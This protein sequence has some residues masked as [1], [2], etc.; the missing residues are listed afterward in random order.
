MPGMA[1][2][3]RLVA[4]DRFKALLGAEGGETRRCP[5]G[6]PV[7]ASISDDFEQSLHALAPDRRDEHGWH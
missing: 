1:S 4:S 6:Y 5:C 3:R 7:I 2:S